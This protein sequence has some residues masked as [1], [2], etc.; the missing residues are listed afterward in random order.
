MSHVTTFGRPR[1]YLRAYAVQSVLSSE[2]TSV[3]TGAQRAAAAR[4]PDPSGDDIRVQHARRSAV[5]ATLRHCHTP[6]PTFRALDAASIAAMAGQSLKAINNVP[7]C[8]GLSA[9]I[10]LRVLLY[11]LL[12][13]IGAGTERRPDTTGAWLC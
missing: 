4:A 5:L 7:A 9:L 1:S 2:R 3:S 8:F 13:C 6:G 10:D 11:W 12:P